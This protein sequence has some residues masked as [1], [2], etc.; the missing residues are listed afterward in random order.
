M[1]KF[2]LM[3][4]VVLVVIASL[5]GCA[6]KKPPQKIDINASG[7]YTERGKIRVS[8]DTNLPKGCILTLLISEVGKT[9][10]VYD[11]KIQ[12][13]KDDGY[14][15]WL[16]TSFDASKDYN[17]NLYFIP[18]KQPKEIQ[19]KYG[20]N[21]EY[22]KKTDDS[23]IEEDDQGKVVLHQTTIIQKKEGLNNGGYFYLQP[24]YEAKK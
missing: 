21:G 9:D 3:L 16:D 12:V 5:M 17:V 24:V 11:E 8:G 10:L 23:G 18:N 1:K 13:E 7:L 19:K 6:I 4:S 22:I 14:F 2:V 20:E 15:N